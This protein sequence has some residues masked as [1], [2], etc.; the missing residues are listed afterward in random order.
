LSWREVSGQVPLA[1]GNWEKRGSEIDTPALKHSFGNLAS[2]DTGQGT[3]RTQDKEQLGKEL[4]GILIW[5]S[6]C[7]L[8]HPRKSTGQVLE[9]LIGAGCEGF[10]QTE[11]QMAKN[12]PSQ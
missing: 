7:R 10:A 5:E 6:N 3:I 11:V 2:S 4:L 8:Q 12:F 9:I 1:A